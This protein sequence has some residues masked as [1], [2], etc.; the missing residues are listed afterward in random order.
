MATR[1]KRGGKSSRSRSRGKRFSDLPNFQK[2]RKRSPDSAPRLYEWLVD[3]GYIETVPTYRRK[4][5]NRRAS[6]R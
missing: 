6:R 2:M 1:S 4:S 3:N 5:A